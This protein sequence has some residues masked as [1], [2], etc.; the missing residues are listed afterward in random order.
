MMQKLIELIV[1]DA[2]NKCL[3]DCSGIVIHETEN[4]FK[5]ITQKDQ[6]KGKGKLFD[7]KPPDNRTPY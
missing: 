3:V 2:K 6:M 1:K 4:T 5:V 7:A